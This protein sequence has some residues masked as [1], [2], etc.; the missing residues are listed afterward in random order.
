MRYE[1][2]VEGN[3]GPHWEVLFD[4]L[5]IGH[6]TTSETSL[7]CDVVDQGSLHGTLARLRDLG[8]V[9]VSI[10]RLDQQEEQH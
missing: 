4:G 10:H 2:I 9:I 1:I 5:R 6:A 8:L 3:V 7:T